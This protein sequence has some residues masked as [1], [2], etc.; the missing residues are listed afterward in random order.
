MA[1]KSLRNAN[2]KALYNEFMSMSHTTEGHITLIPKA[3]EAKLM[4]RLHE[5]LMLIQQKVNESESLTHEDTY[6]VF[7]NIW[8]RFFLADKKEQAKKKKTAYETLVKEKGAPPKPTTA[9]AY[10]CKDEEIRGKVKKQLNK[11]GESVTATAITKVLSE[12]WKS[13]QYRTYSSNGRLT[14]AATKKKY[15][16]TEKALVFADMRVEAIKKYEAFCAQNGIELKKSSTNSKTSTRERKATSKLPIT[17]FIEENPELV[18]KYEQEYIEK[19]GGKQGDD[20]RRFVKSK[21]QVD[22]TLLDEDEKQEYKDK[23]KATKV[24]KATKPAKAQWGIDELQIEIATKSTKAKKSVKEV[25]PD[26]ES[27]DESEEESVNVS[28]VSQT[29]KDEPRNT[30]DRLKAHKKTKVPVPPSSNSI[31]EDEV[32]NDDDTDVEAGGFDDDTDVEAEGFDDEDD[33][34]DYED[35]DESDAILKQFSRVK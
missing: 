34:F 31:H 22:F 11:K 10:F 7:V 13:E 9:F 16:Y 20:C 30:L 24:A 32:E 25:E 14:D 27:A 33:I 29:S 15:D 26:V 5:S 28:R 1:T 23:S 12:I 6:N 4:C 8:P 17:I 19:H 35:D 3:S 21:I 2:R 18:K